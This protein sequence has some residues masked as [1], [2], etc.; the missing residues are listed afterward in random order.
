MA[1]LHAQSTSSVSWIEH[2]M[3]EH[4]KGALRVTLDWNAPSVS[5]QRKKSSVRFSFQS[6]CRHLDRLMRIE[7]RDNYLEELCEVKPYLE[8]QV[9]RL[10]ADHD[11]FRRETHTLMAR[12]E[13]LDEW[14]ADEFDDCCLQIRELLAEVDQHDREEVRILQELLSYDEGGE[15]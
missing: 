10:R 2:Q 9:R 14:Q 3:L 1:V 15:G 6:F 12:L 11:R 7:E 4:V 5:M 13:Q 8:P